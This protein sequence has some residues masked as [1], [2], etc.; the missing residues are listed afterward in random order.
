[1]NNSYKEVTVVII[2]HRVKKS[3]K[4]GKKISNNFK[5]II[6]ENSYDKSIKMDFLIFKKYRNYIF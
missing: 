1:M 5:I 3:F 2:S 6:V 4:F